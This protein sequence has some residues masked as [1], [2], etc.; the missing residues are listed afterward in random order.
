VAADIANKPVGTLPP[1]FDSWAEL[2]AAYR[3]LEEPEVTFERIIAPHWQN[4]RQA[5]GRPGQYL[6]IEDTTSLDFSRRRNVQGLGPIGDGGGTGLYVHSTLAVRVEGWTASHEPTM[7]VVGLLGQQCWVR[8]PEPKHGRETRRERL[9]RPRESGRWAKVFETLDPPRPDVQWIYVA[10]R[11]SDIYEVLE[12]CGRRRLDY[13]VRANQAR[14]LAGKGGSIFEAVGRATPLSRYELRLRARPGVAART[15]VLELRATRV[16]LRPTW[17]PGG[18]LEPLE[19]NVVEAKEVHAPAGVEPIRWVLSFDPEALDGLT[20]LPV[21]TFADARRVV[22]LY[23]KRWLIEEYHKALKTGAGAE[24]T[25]LLTAA[26]IESLLGIL[27]VVAVRL[28]QLK[29]AA[30]ARPDEPVDT[31]VFG[32]EALSILAARYGVPE[33]GWTNRSVTV[34]MARL[35]GYPA[36]RSDGPRGWLTIWRGW[37]RLLLMLQGFL[38]AEGETEKCG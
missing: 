9:Q 21:A 22:A 3:L 35:G 4:T 27:A 13:V 17:R 26:R 33:E 5:C 6:M 7:A 28:L 32:P 14:A 34:A 37:Q 10:D 19:V 38:L 2:K 24:R 1:A 16:T 8:P 11:E 36:R 12:R 23:A 20:S 31:T 15:A 25:E 18:R 29:Y 30:T